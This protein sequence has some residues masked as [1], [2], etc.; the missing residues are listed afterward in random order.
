[1]K[2]VYWRPAKVSRRIHVFIAFAAALGLLAV[3]TYKVRN[4]QQYYKEKLKAARLMRD[5]MNAIREY[6]VREIGPIDLEVDPTGSGM[7]GQLISPIT[8]NTGSLIA[9]QT[10]ANPNWAAVL[11][12]M[13]KRAGVKKGDPIAVAFSGSF[14]AL[15]L[16]VLA[17]SEALEL[18]PAIISSASSSM[19]GANHPK[20]TWLHMEKLM[21]EQRIFSVRSAAASLG[22]QADRGLG[23]GKEGRALLRQSVEETG[24]PLIHA[25]SPQENLELRMARYREV[26]ADE[27]PVLFINV[28][29]GTISVGTT[30][31]KKLFRPGLNRRPPAK[32]LEIDSVMSRFANEG[33]AVIHLIQIVKLAKRYGLPVAP[34]ETPAI[35]DGKIFFREE[36][37]LWLAAGVLLVIIAMLVAFM[38]MDLGHRIFHS[39]GAELG[40][41][42]PERMV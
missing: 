13:M 29:G 34:K 12:H 11:V 23:L 14:P 25:K 41:K 26:L 37:N 10:A 6:H 1:M 16:A 24:A 5:G 40:P 32:A 18:R 31:G 39:G 17:A 19:W 36:Y 33:A 8:S 4:Q 42:Q 15:N 3:E 38:R 22:G 7:M 9:K 20:L 27:Q 2:K 21:F 28:G 35:G 30:V